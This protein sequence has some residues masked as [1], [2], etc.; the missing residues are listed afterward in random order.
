MKKNLSDVEHLIKIMTREKWLLLK[1]VQVAKGG[2]RNRYAI[3]QANP[4]KISDQK[5][6]VRVVQELPTEKEKKSLH[7]GKKLNEQ[8][9]Y[10]PKPPKLKK[11]TDKQD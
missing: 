11:E 3:L 9:N 7:L 8:K 4:A 6:I 2:F 5:L 10:Q 1:S